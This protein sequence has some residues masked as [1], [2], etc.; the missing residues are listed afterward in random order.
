VIEEEAFEHTQLKKLVILGSLQYIGVRMC[1]S[2]TELLLTRESKITKFEK[3]KASFMIN[4]NEVMGYGQDMKWKK[5]M[6]K[7]VELNQTSDIRF[8]KQHKRN[9]DI[10]F[11]IT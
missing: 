8:C 11:C 5:K 9:L 6:E 7:M 10:L 4:R 1:P 3:W 2:K